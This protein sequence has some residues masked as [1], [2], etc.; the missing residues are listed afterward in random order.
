MPALP[1]LPAL[2]AFAATARLGGLARAAA[3][4][5]VSTSAISHQIRTLEELLGTRLLDRS[6]GLGGI[7]PTPAGA[8]L[9]AAA[10]AALELLETACGEIR[11][12]ARRLTVSANVPVSAMWLASRLAK[13]SALHP[14]TPLNAVTHDDIPDFARHGIDLAIVFVRE[15]A[16]RPDDVVLLAEEVFPVCSPDLHPFA[17]Q[18][19]CRCR[20]LQEATEDHTELDWRSWAAEFGL[21]ADFESKIVRYAGFS[22]VIGAA[23]GGAGLALGRSPLIDPELESGRLVRLFPKIARPAS[24]R[25]VL[26]RAPGRRHRMVDALSDFLLAE[27]AGRQPAMAAR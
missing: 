10:D 3:E 25:F 15:K 14:D 27:A 24:W 23:M 2:R 18:A 4:L 26:R 13:F 6:T 16:L 12:T 7:R 17:S 21:P 20:L 9:L 19:V 11:G 22:Q 5:N 8:K 1:S